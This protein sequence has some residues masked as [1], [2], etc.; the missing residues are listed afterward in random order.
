LMPA[1]KNIKSREIVLAFL[2]G[3]GRLLAN[4]TDGV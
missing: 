1:E 2:K 4:Q 3:W